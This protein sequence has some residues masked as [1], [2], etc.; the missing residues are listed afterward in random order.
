[1]HDSAPCAV[2]IV[3]DEPTLRTALE[4]TLGGV[5]HEVSSVSNGQEA[6]DALADRKFD[7]VIMDVRMPLKTGL[8]ALQE[9]RTSGDETPIVLSTAHG[10]PE[11][12]V[13]ALKNR[14]NGFL[15]KPYTPLTI[16][17]AVFRWADPE[18]EEML[19]TFESAMNLVA[20]GDLPGARAFASREPANEVLQALGSALDAAMD[21]IP[22]S[23][24]PHNIFDHISLQKL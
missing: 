17:R 19:S 5:G 6:I 24:L 8:E 4:F 10:P 11:T 14:V 16:R 1:M 2:L 12:V 7:V 18:G 22:I 21:Q 13:T 9:I 3:D 23:D 15:Y 20:K